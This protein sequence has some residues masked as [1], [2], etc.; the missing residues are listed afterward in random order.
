[1]KK[2]VFAIQVFSLIAM[3]PIYVVAEFN[4]GNERSPI[5]NSSSVIIKEVP[6]KNLQSSLNADIK[7]GEMV[8]FIFNMN[9]F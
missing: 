5:D 2:A 9:L 4:H 8:L 3:F 1:M 7:N 6:K